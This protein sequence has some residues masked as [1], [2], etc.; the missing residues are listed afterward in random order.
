MRYTL[1][2]D[3]EIKVIRY[4]HSGNIGLN[5]IGEAWEELFSLKQFSELNYNLLS[6]Y[7]NAS[8][9]LSIE[10][11]SLIS[12]YLMKFKNTLK[13]KKQAL[14]VDDAMKVAMSMIFE[15]EV[16]EKVGFIVK[17]FSTVESANNWLSV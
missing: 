7:R 15:E 10:D 16:Y 4:K 14:I 1:T 11:A 17:T 3:D 9:N 6:D 2:I 12:D 5:D 13:R 8:F